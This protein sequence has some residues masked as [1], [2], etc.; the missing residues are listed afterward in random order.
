MPKRFIAVAVSL[1]LL[2]LLIQARAAEPASR[3][4]IR[5]AAAQAKNRTINFRLS[6]GDALAAVDKNLAELE[7]L[8]HRAGQAKCD[9]LCLPEDTPGL[10]NWIGMHH[11]D[12]KEV[13]PK[14]LDHMIGRLG[15]AAAAHHMYLIVCADVLD[16]DGALSNTA[17]FLGRDGREIG[18]YR[19]V[20][21]TYSES[22]KP[23]SSFPVYPTKDLGSVGMLICYDLVFPETA[24][25]LALQGADIIFF[26]TMGTAAI[27]DDDIGLQALRVRAAENFIWIIVAHRGS[28][29]M[30][31][32]PQG[33]IIAKAEGPEGLAIADIDPRGSREGGDAMNHQQDMRARLFRER[34]PAAFG[35]LTQPNP[36]IL[37]KVPIDLTREQAGQ[38]SARAMTLGEEEFK[39]ASALAAEKKTDAAIEA[40]TRL[41]KEYRGTWIDRVS[42]QRLMEL[43]APQP[44]R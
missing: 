1:P 12:L 6:P 11:D 13:L 7:S 14:A 31:I 9:A 35:I 40:F 2:M 33:K 23:G 30:I 17:I 41:R 36:P 28:G 42:Q 5:I 34:N 21:P 24:R 38:I 22:R 19:K 3:P 10:L 15:R 44:P 26:P 18:R 16:D 20:C 4:T 32:S 29:A 27:G 37:A 8:I 25:C 43:S 39:A